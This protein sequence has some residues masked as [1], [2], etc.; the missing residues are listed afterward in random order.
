MD[1]NNIASYLATTGVD[2]LVK[3]ADQNC[4]GI[5][6]LAYWSL[7]YCEIDDAGEPRNCQGQQN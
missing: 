5:G 6:D 2:L 4:C 1:I 7:D 3:I